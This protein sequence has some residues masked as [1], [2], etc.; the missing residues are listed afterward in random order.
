[1]CFHVYSFFVPS[2]TNSPMTLKRRF[3]FMFFPSSLAVFVGN[4]TIAYILG[5]API[6]SPCSWREANSWMKSRNLCCAASL[7]G[8]QWSTFVGF[9]T[10]LVGESWETDW[11]MDGVSVVPTESHEE[12]RWGKNGRDKV[13]AVIFSGWCSGRIWLHGVLIW[14]IWMSR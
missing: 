13:A 12:K 10:H 8:G 9:Q 7:S 2:G 6:A 5:L 14:C 1:M 3:F 11:L 4:N